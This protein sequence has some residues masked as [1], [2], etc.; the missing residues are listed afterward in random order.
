MQGGGA[1]LIDY[2]AVSSAVRVETSMVLDRI[3]TDHRTIDWVLVSSKSITTPGALVH[4]A[5]V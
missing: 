3:T 5:I 4:L 2:V 1:T